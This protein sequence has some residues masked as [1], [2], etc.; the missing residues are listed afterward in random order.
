MCRP[1]CLLMVQ[2]MGEGRSS[3]LERLCVGTEAAVTPTMAGPDSAASGHETMRAGD[4]II[5]APAFPGIE[6]IEARFAGNG[7]E[8]HR[9]D[10]YA[11]GVTLQGVQTFHYRG[12]QRF[13]L[14]GN[15]LVLHPDELHDGGAGSEAGLCYRMLYLEPSLLA[16][17]LEEGRGALPFGP[18]PVLSDDTLQASLL[19]ALET[20]DTGL[21]DLFVTGLL[22]EIARGL[23][24]HAGERTRPVGTLARR[25]MQLA[26]DYLI[27]H[28]DRPVSSDELETV[29]GLDRFQLA[30]QFRAC[31]ATSPHRFL[32]MRRLE[33]ARQMIA[34]QMIDRQMINRGDTLAGIAAATGVADPSHFNRHF[35]KAYGMTPGRWS[36]LITA[37]T[38]PGR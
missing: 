14:P 4:A 37:R 24:R 21:D 15:I 36:A 1:S 17:H 22:S 10:T 29:T 18:A 32:L 5:A 2:D 30:R 8:P 26:R 25:Q 13:S 9:H 23:T 20:L 35:K 34:Q 7:F 38:P 11:I 19:E 31:F 27:A 28:A 3:G 6:R 16:A 12:A 33:R